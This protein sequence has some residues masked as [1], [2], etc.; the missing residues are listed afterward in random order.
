PGSRSRRSSRSSVYGPMRSEPVSPRVR[1][2][3]ITRLGRVGDAKLCIDPFLEGHR[4]LGPRSRDRVHGRGGPGERRDARHAAC[5]RGLANRVAV[6]ARVATF[7]R[8]DHEVAA[9]TPDEIDHP[10]LAVC[11]LAELPHRPGGDPGRR[12]GRGGGSGGSPSS[13]IVAPSASRQAAL[14]S[15]TPVALLTNGTVRDARGFASSTYT[16]PSPVTASWT[17]RSPTVPSAFPRIR[18]IRAISCPCANDRLGAGRTQAE[19]PEWT[20]A[21]STCCMT[22]A[23]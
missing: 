19:S 17:L 10:R 1:F 7:R 11:R 23:T 2:E 9:T 21:S 18:T 4:L 14:T 22:A 16:S 15:S 3:P 5:E 12:E 8:V 13:A 6:G 20:P